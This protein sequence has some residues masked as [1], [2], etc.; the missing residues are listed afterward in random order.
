MTVGPSSARPAG[1]GRGSRASGGLSE[2]E[3]SRR[4]ATRVRQVGRP[5]SRSYASIVRA[6]VFTVFNLIL[7]VAG[8][9]TLAFGQW[10]DALFLG[11]LVANAVIGTAQEVRAKRA[12]DR[13]TALVA[14]HA[15]VVSGGEERRVAVDDVRVGDLVR[16]EPGDQVVAD[17][18]LEHAVELRLDESILT[19]ES[20]PVERGAGE[21][22][23]SGAFAVEG[24]GTY[25]VT[26]VGAASYAQRIAGEA[27]AF[28]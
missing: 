19:G 23:R 24:S 8:A 4:R 13:L 12:L 17:G 3:A 16:I 7:A 14:P 11:V 27:R 1:A 18:V 15:R 26:A 20:R 9:A 10:Q 2:A 25:R 5:A 22:G 21:E 28:R 6:N